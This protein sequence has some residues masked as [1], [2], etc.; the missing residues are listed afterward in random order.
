M[1]PPRHIRG[2]YCDPQKLPKGP[3][4]RAL[5]RQCSTEVKAPRR[6]FCSS[7]CVELWTL[8]TGSGMA[9]FIKKRDRGVCALCGLDC[10]ALKRQ[11]RKILKA[12]EPARPLY[13]G[14]ADYQDDGTLTPEW[15]TRWA[16]HEAQRKN[17]RAAMKSAALEFKSE[18]GIPPHRTRFWDTDHIVPVAEGGGDCDG[19]NLRC[20]CIPCHHKITQEFMARRR[21]S[22]DSGAPHEPKSCRPLS[23]ERS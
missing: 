18:H 6:T 5:C 17:A 10:E 15:K 14:A 16:A 19:S 23:R 8:R 1:Q 4:G 20:L 21:A 2:G 9:R 3:N 13:P 7:K 22:R 11:L 12:L